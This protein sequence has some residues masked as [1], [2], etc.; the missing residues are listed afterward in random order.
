MYILMQYIL[1]NSDERIEAQRP[2]SQGAAIYQRS[3]SNRCS[4]IM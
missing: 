1:S 3:C 4:K 2:V